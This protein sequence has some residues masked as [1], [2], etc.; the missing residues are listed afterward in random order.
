MW[1]YVMT[2]PMVARIIGLLGVGSLALWGFVK[3]KTIAAFMGAAK[4]AAGEHFW[5]YVR[6]KLQTN[7]KQIAQPAFNEKTYRGIFMGLAQYEN[8]PNEHCITLIDEHGGGT[9]KIPVARTNLLSGVQHGALVKI[10]TRP[11]SVR[12]EAVVR[13]HVLRDGG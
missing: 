13:V 9:M 6:G 8:Y 12:E 4:D 3:H 5:G 2:L 11:F 7:S 10:D 1:H